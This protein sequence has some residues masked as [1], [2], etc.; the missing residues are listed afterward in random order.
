MLGSKIAVLSQRLDGG[1]GIGLEKI[2][3][4]HVYVSQYLS[5]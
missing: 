2:T 5:V 1:T 4:F 3:I